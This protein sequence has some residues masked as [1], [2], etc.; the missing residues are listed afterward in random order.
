M[1]KSGWSNFNKE[2]GMWNVDVP[3]VVVVA[4]VVAVIVADVVTGIG[5][6]VVVSGLQFLLILV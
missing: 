3:A 1:R 6:G 5:V 4:I 2:Y